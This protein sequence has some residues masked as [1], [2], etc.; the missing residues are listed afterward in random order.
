MRA[1]IVRWG[2]TL[3][4]LLALL[5]FGVYALGGES[6]RWRARVAV[7]VATGQ[8]PDLGLIEA[9][10]M[11][12]PGSGYWLEGLVETRSPYASISNPHKE[13]ADLESGAALFR[14]NCAACHGADARGRELAPALVGRTLKHGDSDWALYRTVQNG[15]SG[16]PMPAHAWDAK[17]IWQTISYL[18]SLENSRRHL[19]VTPG[20]NAL[21]ANVDVPYEELAAIDDPSDDWLTYSGSYSGARHSKLAQI[22]RDNVARLAPRWIYQ[23]GGEGD[24][25]EL[26]PLVRGGVMYLTHAGRVIALDAR[27]GRQIWEFARS[28]PPDIKLCCANA[29]RGLAILGDK[30]FIGTTDAWL[31]AVSARTGEG[32]W[33]TPVV[34]D[35]RPGYSI[36]SAPLAYRGLV[37]TGISGGDYPTRGF[38]A[39]F[40][41]GTGKERWRFS[42]VPAPGQPGN[43]TWAGDSWRHGGGATWLTGSYDPKL[44]VLY[45]GV[46]NPAPD[47]NAASRKGDNLYTNSV[48]A[49]RG[50]TGEKL[51]HFQ[52]TPGDDHDWDSNQIPVIADRAAAQSPQQQLLWANRNGFFYVL[53][54]QTGAFVLGKPFVHQT[55]A[56]RLTETGR[57]VRS[58]AAAPTPKGTLL[59]P[60]ISGATHWWSPSYDAELDLMVVP[61]IERG[62][63]FFSFEPQK[64]KAGELYPAG[65]T[66][67]APGLASYSKVVGISPKDGTILWE[68]RGTPTTGAV[69]Q[70]GLMTT[71]GGLVFASDDELF[72]ALDTRDG[73]LLWSFPSGA[74]INSPPMA[75]AVGGTQYVLVAAGHTLIAF[76]LVDEGH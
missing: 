11:L 51:W 26:S 48:V 21:T 10:R 70:A 71:H 65:A 18:R 8:V 50:S 45:W 30:L 73:K 39:A 42:T 19:S 74:R 64:P 3:L 5:G 49:L 54:R 68:H 72:Y 58:P 76:A 46:G 20:A 34:E 31:I 47:F 62:G 56:E 63:L 2:L 43:D 29:T 52:F 55:W 44:D 41:A 28:V 33:Q 27:N 23:L 9:L 37:V 61:A 12:R 17:R 32:L 36:T 38:I 22:N 69:R 67:G 57:P 13:P 1:G 14:A 59:Y 6:L 25:V 15:I 7:L 16:T 24:P 75:Y 60:S 35:Y 53:D 66:S 40:D 4:A